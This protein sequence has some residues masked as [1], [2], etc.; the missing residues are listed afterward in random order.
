MV[1]LDILHNP[2]I[3]S[4]MGVEWVS[5][6]ICLCQ[7]ILACIWHTHDP[8]LFTK[9]GALEVDS[10]CQDVFAALR[11]HGKE[12][13]MIRQYDVKWICRTMKTCYIYTLDDSE[14]SEKFVKE[15]SNLSSYSS[16]TWP[17]YTHSQYGACTFRDPEH[18]WKSCR[19]NKG[20]TKESTKESHYN[21]MVLWMTT[22]G[23]MWLR[24]LAEGILL[25]TWRIGTM[26]RTLMSCW[27]S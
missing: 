13:A 18:P 23:S 11:G 8:S 12:F 20:S 1:V 27:R 3:S 2:R 24:W 14:W 5:W 16:I 21:Q 19:N 22:A 7:L 4:R 15:S 26:L 17:S 9:R 6:P 10:I 25:R